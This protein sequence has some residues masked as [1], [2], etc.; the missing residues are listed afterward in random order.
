MTMILLV[1]TLLTLALNA[2]IANWGFVL[3][4]IAT[5]AILTVL[6]VLEN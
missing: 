4:N 3:V 6:L 1:F 5:M 2:W